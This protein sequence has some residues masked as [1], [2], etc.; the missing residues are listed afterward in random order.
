MN[1]ALDNWNY[2]NDARTQGAAKK[3]VLYYLGCRNCGETEQ[4]CACG[5]YEE[6]DLETALPMKWAVCPVCEGE[7]KHVNPSI[8]AGGLSSEDFCEDHEFAEAYMDGVYDVT[9]NR[10]EGKRVVPDVDRSAMSKWQRDA[11]DAQLIEERNDHA[12]YL[13]EIRAG[14]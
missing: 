4:E 14:C 3:P 1:Y 9:C 12:E 10:C 8:D 7:G 13:A 11:Y 6:V 2:A 5:S